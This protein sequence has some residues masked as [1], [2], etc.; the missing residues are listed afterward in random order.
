MTS[1]IKIWREHKKLSGIVGMYGKI[2]SW[3]IIRVAPDGFEDQTPYPVVLVKLND[4]RNFLAQMVDCNQKQL[5][6]GQK[7][8]AVVRRLSKPLPDEV[9][10]YGIK[11]KPV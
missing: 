1:P 2:I 5:K 7:V 9:I 11:M 10:H 3:T 4:G 6:L 8:V